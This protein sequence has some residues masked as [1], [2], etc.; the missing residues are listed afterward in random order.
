MKLWRWLESNH[1]VK[2]IYGLIANMYNLSIVLPDSR[3]GY[4]IAFLP[5]CE[6]HAIRHGPRV[7]K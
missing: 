6:K 7:C 2:N 5:M 1:Y 4:G 3:R